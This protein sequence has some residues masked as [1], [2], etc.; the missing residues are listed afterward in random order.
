MLGGPELEPK[1]HV[2]LRPLYNKIS[3]TIALTDVIHDFIGMRCEVRK[4]DM[5]LL[6]TLA[7]EC[8]CGILKEVGHRLPSVENHIPY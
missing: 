1:P 2:T 6:S 3:S 5:A 4:L 8:D 7:E